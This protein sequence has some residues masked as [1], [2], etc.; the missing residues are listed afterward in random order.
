M[1]EQT[2]TVLGIGRQYFR[3]EFVVR[4]TKNVLVRNGLKNTTYSYYE[5]PCHPE[6]GVTLIIPEYGPFKTEEDLLNDIVKNFRDYEGN[7]TFSVRLI[8]S[9]EEVHT[10]M[11]VKSIT[12]SASDNEK[13][14]IQNSLEQ[15]LSILRNF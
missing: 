13:M 14:S 9:M 5:E 4:I 7:C 10:R 6:K 15:K 8:F 2:T 11:Q 12:M 1:E 3:E